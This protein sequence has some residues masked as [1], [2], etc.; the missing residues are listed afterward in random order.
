M[1]WTLAPNLLIC[2]I[3]KET[4]QR[5]FNDKHNSLKEIW[6]LYNI[7]L[8]ENLSLTS[9]V[10]KD[11][12]GTPKE[13]EIL[14]WWNFKLFKRNVASSHT[15]TPAPSSEIW[16]PPLYHHYKLNFDDTSKGNPRESGIIRVI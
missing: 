9:W 12:Q 16:H 4:N 10:D 15:R 14:A 7:Q 2:E 13:R 11:F 3:W 5:I 8:E 1:M 6:Q